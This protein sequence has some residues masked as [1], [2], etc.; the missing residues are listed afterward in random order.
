[1]LRGPLVGRGPPVEKH[2]SRASHRPLAYLIDG[3]DLQLWTNSQYKFKP[4]LQCQRTKILP[5]QK[6]TLTFLWKIGKSM[7]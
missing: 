2:C 6:C 1:M 3:T 4:N 7:Y 5:C